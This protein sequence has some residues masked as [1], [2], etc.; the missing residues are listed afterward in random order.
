MGVLLAR[1]EH[2]PK[3]GEDSG[4]TDGSVALVMSGEFRALDFLQPNLDMASAGLLGSTV[5][6]FV[7]L[8][9][10]PLTRDSHG[11]GK[12]TAKEPKRLGVCVAGAPALC[13]RPR[14]N[15]Y[16]AGLRWPSVGD[17]AVAASAWRSCA[18]EFV[19]VMQ[20]QL[21]AWNCSAGQ[22]SDAMPQIVKLQR[23]FRLVVSYERREREG[24]PFAWLVRLR[25]DIFFFS[26]LPSL[27]ALESRL[28][29]GRRL[30][31]SRPDGKAQQR[32][33]FV[34][35]GVVS[36]QT[37]HNDHLAL[38]P[39]SLA[40]SY[41][42]AADELACDASLHSPIAPS[43]RRTLV[44]RVGCACTTANMR[45]MRTRPRYAHMKL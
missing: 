28:P 29:G 7:H 36:S 42:D 10:P 25:T 12:R 44:G 32:V 8:E 17:A 24:H 30:D 26:Q 33:I 31:S 20:E 18:A 38:V 43:R 37:P 19:Y 11:N 14:A 9:V 21:S 45:T 2:S 39:R 27:A 41:F 6:S 35:R 16:R 40:S 34:P 5:V 15:S 1:A 13:E 4:V 3:C 23:A 22:A